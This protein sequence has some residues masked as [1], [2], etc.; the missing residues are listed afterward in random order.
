MGT[1]IQPQAIQHRKVQI[2]TIQRQAILHQKQKEKD[3]FQ[4][5][6]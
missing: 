6:T 3:F 1:L 4:A 2:L 5:L